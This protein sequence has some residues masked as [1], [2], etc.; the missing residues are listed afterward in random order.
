MNNKNKSQAERHRNWIFIVYPD[1][2]PKNWRDIVTDIGAPWGHSPLH[3]KDENEYGGAK[4]PHYHCLIKFNSLKSYRQ[5]LK[6]TGKIHAPNP[7]PCESIVGKVR[8]WLHLDNPE[9][10][11]YEQENIMAF[12]G[13]DVKEILRPS[14][15]QQTA[16]MREIRAFIRENN[17]KEMK[18]FMDYADEEFP[19]WGYVINRYHY[20]IRDYIN[21][22]RY[23]SKSEQNENY[24]GLHLIRTF[25]KDN[26]IT[27]ISTVYDFLDE[28]APQ[29]GYLMDTNYLEINS[30]LQSTIRRNKHK[31]QIN[32]FD[33]STQTYNIPLVPKGVDLELWALTLKEYQEFCL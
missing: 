31:V 30:Y 7:Q 9:K 29:W 19:R 32:S 23:S 10:Y 12:N 2:A 26:G 22:C 28:T 5:M 11:Q 21:S 15:T 33:S 6:I 13:L 27:E 1:S 18:D 3:D 8:Y 16:M 24:K 17:I 20:G 4:K 25:I 14:K